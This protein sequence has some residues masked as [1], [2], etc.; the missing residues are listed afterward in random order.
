M[1]RWGQGKGY[2]PHLGRGHSSEGQTE[3]GAWEGS[4]MAAGAA[5]G[6]WVLVLSLWGEPLPTPLLPAESTPPPPQIF[7]EL[8]WNLGTAL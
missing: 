8:A 1:G 6:A 2:K 4:R 7:P 3:P 5:V